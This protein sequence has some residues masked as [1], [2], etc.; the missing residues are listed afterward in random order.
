VIG[1]TR[2]AVCDDSPTYVHA[3]SRVLETGGDIEVVGR[4]G[5]AEELLAALPGLNA[6]LVTMD[7][8]LPGLDGVTATRRVLAE[9]PVPVVVVSSHTVQGSVRV[10][11]ALAAGAVDVLHKAD[12]RLGDAAGPDGRALRRRIRRLS[13]VRVRATVEPRMYRDAGAPTPELARAGHLPVQAVGIAAST[14]GPRALRRVLSF[15]PAAPTVPVLVVQHMT[16]GFIDGLARW[17]DANTPPPV[18]VAEAGPATPGVWLAPDDGHL[19]MGPDLRLR[20]DRRSAA[21]PH[22]P[23]ADVLLCSLAAHLGAGAAAVVLT[24]MGRDGARGTR[25]VVEAGG[26]AI[27]QAET[28]AT[29]AGMPRAAAAAGAQHVLG[30]DEIGPLLAA[31]TMPAKTLA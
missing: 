16:A 21:D 14:G 6:D 5:S 9:H 10:A 8:E 7:L 15:L 2:I 17:L 22:R 23:S 18:R 12:V 29:V 20:L 11:E 24:G 30:L 4:Y 31:L 1:K 27:A 3:L 13:R 26:L 28:H 19:L 25:A